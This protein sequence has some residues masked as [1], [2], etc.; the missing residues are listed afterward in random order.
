MS[1]YRVT[2]ANIHY[3]TAD[4]EA[5]SP[6]EAEKIAKDDYLTELGTSIMAYD[7]DSYVIEGEAYEIKEESK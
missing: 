4:I 6:E 3:Y 7:G 1:K 5:D 2:M